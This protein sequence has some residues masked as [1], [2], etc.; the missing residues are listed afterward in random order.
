MEFHRIAV[1]IK[2]CLFVLVIVVGGGGGGGGEEKD[3]IEF[4][5]YNLR[6]TVASRYVAFIESRFP[7]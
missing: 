6:S 3:T 1:Y 7:R 5:R 4:M 2:S